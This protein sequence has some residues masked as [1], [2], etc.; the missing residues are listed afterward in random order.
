M[1]CIYH[2]DK[3]AVAKCAEC[4]QYLCDSCK[5]LVGRTVYCRECYGFERSGY[6]TYLRKGAD[7]NKNVVITLVSGLSLC[8]VLIVVGLCINS[9]LASFFI[10]GGYLICGIAVGITYVINNSTGYEYDVGLSEIFKIKKNNIM[11]KIFLFNIGVA[12][13]FFTVIFTIIRK[14][15]NVEYFKSETVSF[16]KASAKLEGQYIS[17][18]KTDP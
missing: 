16:K 11:S 13:G 1:N 17:N 6:M 7:N 10:I 9:F 12:T 14:A 5:I 3:P 8:A 18:E 15:K 2:P 4:G